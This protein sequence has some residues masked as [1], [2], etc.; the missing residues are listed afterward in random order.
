MTALQKIGRAY[1][2]RTNPD[3]I[4]REMC[5]LLAPYGRSISAQTIRNW[6]ECE[7]RAVRKLPELIIVAEQAGD[8]GDFAGDMLAAFMPSAFQPRGDIGRAL[9]AKQDNRKGAK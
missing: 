5:A 8:I 9:L 6:I 4:A 1:L 2:K 3:Q 7:P